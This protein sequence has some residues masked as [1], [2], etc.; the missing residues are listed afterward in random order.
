MGYFPGRGTKELSED[1]RHR[2]TLHSVC[3]TGGK[4]SPPPIAP[5]ACLGHSPLVLPITI[6]KHWTSIYIYNTLRSSILLSSFL[7]NLTI[8]SSVVVVSLI[9]HAAC[10]TARGR[11]PTDLTNCSAWLN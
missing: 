9:K 10:A 4:M 11:R 2:E 5:H 8:S 7:Y 3:R 1:C 6:R